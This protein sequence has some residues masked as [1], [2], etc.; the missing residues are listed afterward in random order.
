MN[1]LR[2]LFSPAPNSTSMMRL[3]LVNILIMDY[4]ILAVWIAGCIHAGKIVD[5][6]AQ[7]AAFAGMINGAA[8]AGKGVQTFAERRSYRQEKEC[9]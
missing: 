9:D 3:A 2:D 7:I 6:G 4:L 5:L 1:Y 8:F